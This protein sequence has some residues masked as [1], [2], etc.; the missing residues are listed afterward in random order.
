MS[1]SV[2]EAAKVLGV[3]PR[4][5]L[6]LINAGRIPA[7]KIGRDWY[8]EPGERRRR[9]GRPLS[10][11]NAW[12]VLAL[13]SNERAWWLRADV[14]SRVK[15]YLKDPDMLAL[16]LLTSAPRSQVHRLRVLSSDLKGLEQDCRLVRTGLSADPSAIALVNAPADLDAYGG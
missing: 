12:A 5:V 3:S 11:A 9:T 10:S 8:V 15:R 13:L 14:A 16:R 1:V 7:V 2:Q 6:A 4:R